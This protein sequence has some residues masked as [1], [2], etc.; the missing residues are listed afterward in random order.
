MSYTGFGAD[1][2]VTSAMRG[3]ADAKVSAIMRANA[4]EMKRYDDEVKKYNE[5]KAAREKVMLK[6]ANDQKVYADA[7]AR[8]KAEAA[9]VDTVNRGM[10]SS[11]SQ[12]YSQW[13]AA[14]DRYAGV[15]AERTRL[16]NQQKSASDFVLKKVTPPPGYAG[17]VTQAEH[18]A[19]VAKCKATPNVTVKGIG[20]VLFGLGGDS[21]ECFWAQLPVCVALPALPA[22]PGP[23][24]QKP[25]FLTPPTP[26]REPA[27][28]KIPALPK[29]PKKPKLQ[30]VPKVV[31]RDDA[32][33]TVAL[34]PQP[35]SFA[36]AGL[37]ALVIVG[38]GAA[39][40]FTH[41]KKK[42][43]A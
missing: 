21:A 7:L 27:V 8:Y 26:P 20:Q 38:G 6:A 4:A 41:K 40:Y 18:D 39:Y 14:S 16:L 22:Q 25:K 32:P 35:K 31:V 34:E 1:L 11:Y 2:V 30:E 17:C 33:P 9:R 43:A 36:V 37:L 10:G 12:A 23:E 19:Y 15:L 3:Q 29:L 28:P 42:A 5:A 24:P 13:K